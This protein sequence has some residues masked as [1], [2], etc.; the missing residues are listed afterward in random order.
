MISI[1]LCSIEA[2]D[3]VEFK[4]IWSK[5]FG[6]VP[7]TKNKYLE[8]QLYHYG[9]LLGLELSLY[10]KGR[11]H[12]G[13]RLSVSFLTLTFEIT[14]YDHRHWNDDTNDWCVY[15]KDGNEL[16][17][18]GAVLVWDREQERMVKLKKPT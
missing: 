16:D 4:D 18:E 5:D 2:W 10:W 14:I 1:T 11:D 7:W 13:P 9:T 8:M 3:L 12:A 6:R 15:D 17:E